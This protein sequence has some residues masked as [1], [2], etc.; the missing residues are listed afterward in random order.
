MKT[1]HGYIELYEGKGKDKE[2]YPSF[3]R[4]KPLKREILNGNEFGYKIYKCEIKIGKE[5]KE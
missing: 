4:K 2:P 3:M 5:I 1:I